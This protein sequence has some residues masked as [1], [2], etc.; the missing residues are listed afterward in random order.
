MTRSARSWQRVSRF[1]GVDRLFRHDDLDY[2]GPG[3]GWGPAPPDEYTLNKTIETLRAESSQ[4]LFLFTITQNSHYPWV[5]LP[6]FV[7]DWRTLVH[8][9]AG[10]RQPCR[11][12]TPNSIAHA[13]R[14]HNYLRAV[15]YQLQML[16]RLIE[17]QGDDNSLFVLV[18]DH[19]PPRRFTP[20]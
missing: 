8:S 1:Y 11:R 16:A 2:Q 5:P 18:G 4:P 6:T 7:D 12:S 9:D 15:T 10:T 14:R 13:E 17:V 19:Q 3:Y 20:Q